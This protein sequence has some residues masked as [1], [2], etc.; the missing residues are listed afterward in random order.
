MHPE[1]GRYSV[2]ARYIG[3]HITKS[4]NYDMVFSATEKMTMLYYLTQPFILSACFIC[5][6]MM[7]QSVIPFH[8]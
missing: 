4:R 3:Y 5:I 1:L 6:D 2:T 7:F 8:I